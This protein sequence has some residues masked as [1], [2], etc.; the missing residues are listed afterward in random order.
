MKTMRFRPPIAVIALFAAGAANAA[1]PTV[2]VV[3]QS[4]DASG[5]SYLFSRFEG[6]ETFLIDALGRTINTWTFDTELGLTQY[7]LPGGNLVRMGR[8]DDDS[9]DSFG[10]GGRGGLIE[11]YDWDGALQWSTLIADTEFRA[12]HD[13]EALPN[14]NV[15]VI[16]WERMSTDDAIAAGRDP[17]TMTS[18]SLWSE[19]IFE[20][21]PDGL[22]GA[23]VVW[24]W[25]LWDHLIQDFDPTRDNFG[26]VGAHPERLDINAFLGMNADWCH[27]NSI[28]YHSGR[29]E[30]ALGS[31]ALSEFWIID[32]ST[33]TEEA[34]GPAGD[35]RYRWGNPRNYRR[36]GFAEQQLFWQHDVHWIPDGRPGAGN[37]LMFNNGYLRPDG[38]I[39]SIEEVT[40]PL[41]RQGAYVLQRDLA[42]M[43]RT[44]TWQ[45]M[46]DPPTDFFSRFLSGTDRMPNGNTLMC[47]GARGEFIERR[48][49]GSIAWHYVSPLTSSGPL[50]QGTVPGPLNSWSNVNR[51]FQ[52]E[53]YAPD[54]PELFGLDLTPGPRLELY[55]DTC[56]ADI[57][58]DGAVN[59][60][61]LIMLLGAWGPCNKCRD[62]IDQ[63]DSVGHQDLILLLHAWGECP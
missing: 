26:D 35:F 45:F 17:E 24:T 28:D 58:G 50:T 23:D 39:S 15:L 47:N 8:P 42:W 6:H 37:F 4:P 48:P 56:A 3:H 36:G 11:V 59:T 52:V 2:G 27:G 18:T 46:T 51:V 16:V 33:S 31:G 12:H 10:G 13:V 30:I 43:P 63:N 34:A 22:G 55:D 19:A 38:P 14:G 7:L 5:G 54:A 53:W 9:I 62:D 20:L 40:P 21:Q 57:S 44:A 41:N 32:H 1:L 60:I 25:R 61:D 29:D 49:D